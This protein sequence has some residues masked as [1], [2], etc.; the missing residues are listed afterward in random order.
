MS[1]SRL[2]VHIKV[3]ESGT[4]LERVLMV[5]SVMWHKADIMNTK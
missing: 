4:Y 1:Q 3:W 5:V 2:H